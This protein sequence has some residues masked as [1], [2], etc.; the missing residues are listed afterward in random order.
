MRRLEF[1]HNQL[2]DSFINLSGSSA[3]AHL[4]DWRIAALHNHVNLGNVH[5]IFKAAE[6]DR[7][8]LIDFNNNDFRCL[9]ACRHMRGIRSEI[10]ISVFS[11]GATWNIATSGLEADSL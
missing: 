1:L 2:C 3:C 8:I 4:G 5:Y 11:I 6:A 10:K 9:T 7:H